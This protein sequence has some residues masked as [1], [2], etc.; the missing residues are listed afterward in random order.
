MENPCTPAKRRLEVKRPSGYLPEIA[1]WIWALEDV[2]QTVKQLLEGISQEQLDYQPPGRHSVG[3]L[4]HHI[5]LIESD[6]LFVEVMETDIDE[7]LKA[8]LPYDNLTD[9]EMTAVAGQTLAQHLARLDA[10]RAKLL[11]C[12]AQMDLADWSRARELPNY[13]VTPEWVLY[14]LVEHEAHHRGQMAETLRLLR[15]EGE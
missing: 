12:F 4:L 14:H 9:G 13:T 11:A 5:A 1:P 15:N 2:R 6:W 10:V 8:L 7:D 3:S